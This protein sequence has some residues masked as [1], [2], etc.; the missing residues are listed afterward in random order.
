MFIEVLCISEHHCWNNDK[1]SFWV[2]ESHLHVGQNQLC[3]PWI[4]YTTPHVLV[5]LTHRLPPCIVHQQWYKGM[6]HKTIPKQQPHRHQH[7]VCLR[8]GF[9]HGHWKMSVL[10]HNIL[11][12]LRNKN[13]KKHT[14][15]KNWLSSIASNIEGCQQMQ[16]WGRMFYEHW[17]RWVW[18][19]RT[20]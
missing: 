15:M 4:G 5:G 8:T 7:Q 16:A 17:R 2:D 18:P 14:F 12:W 3:Q 11:G 19:Q 10:T 20:R 1:V 6:K 9:V 13:K